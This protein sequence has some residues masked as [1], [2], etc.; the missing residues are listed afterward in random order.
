[1]PYNR[2][3]NDKTGEVYYETH[4]GLGDALDWMMQRADQ[5]VLQHGREGVLTEEVSD[6]GEI[7]GWWT[8]GSLFDENPNGW[9]LRDGTVIREDSLMDKI[10]Q[11][12]R[13]LKT[14]DLIKALAGSGEDWE[15]EHIDRAIKETG[16]MIFSLADV[17]CMRAIHNDEFCENER[18]IIETGVQNMS[19]L[20]PNAR[21]TYYHTHVFPHANMRNARCEE[22]RKTFDGLVYYTTPYHVKED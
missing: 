9:L 22:I 20:E 14:H 1:M 15:Q 8:I 4:S 2:V 16:A 10:N 21:L 13:C 12:I 6:S 3:C 18:V 5:F 19:K 11:I 7:L 17:A